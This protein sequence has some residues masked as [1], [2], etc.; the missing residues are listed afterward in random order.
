[1]A[2]VCAITLLRALPPTGQLGDG[3][4]NFI[5]ADSAEA[6][7]VLTGL[8]SPPI[9]D[10]RQVAAG[11]LH[12]CLLQGANLDV[13]CWGERASCLASRRAAQRSVSAREK[14]AG[15]THV[16]LRARCR[17]SHPAGNNEMNQASFNSPNTNLDFP[18]PVPLSGGGTLQQVRYVAAGGYTSCVIDDS[19]RVMCWGASA[20]GQTGS[21]S[22]ANMVDH[23]ALVLLDAP[24]N[25]PLAGVVSLSLGEAHACASTSASQMLHC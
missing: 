13:L 8:N 3:L 12:S 18:T 16:C 23:P 4:G 1:M 11:G 5:L 9:A 20:E 2:A 22:T 15:A 6:V 17:C 10:V 14:R 24:P 7:R 25:A 21:G 19:A